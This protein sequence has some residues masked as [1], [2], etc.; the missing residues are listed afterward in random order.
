MVED[1]MGGAAGLA[2]PFIR[3]I[4]HLLNF[5]GKKQ[6]PVD[7]KKLPFPDLTRNVF[8]LLLCF[9]DKPVFF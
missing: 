2:P 9:A 8:Y 7:Q 4:L 6:F 1:R 5:C 3:L